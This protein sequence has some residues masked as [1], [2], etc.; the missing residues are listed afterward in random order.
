MNESN[1]VR[2]KMGALDMPK[3]NDVIADGSSVLNTDL[4][5]LNAEETE[6]RTETVDNGNGSHVLNK[7]NAALESEVSKTAK[8]FEWSL[9]D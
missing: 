4:I 2:G 1:A 9:T 3:Q 5:E 8:G 7:T 6:Y